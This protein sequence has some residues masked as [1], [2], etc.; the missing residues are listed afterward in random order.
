MND[1]DNV[2]NDFEYSRKTYYDLIEKGNNALE[3]MMEVAKALEH[4]RALRLFLG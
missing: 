1:S 3:E 2:N 4:P